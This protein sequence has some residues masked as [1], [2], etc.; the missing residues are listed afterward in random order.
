[1]NEAC[2]NLLGEDIASPKGKDFAVKVL[3][4]MRDKLV[5]FQEETGNIFN[6]KRLRPRGLLTVWPNWIRPCTWISSALMK[7]NM[8]KAMNLSIPIRRICR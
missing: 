6:L 4:F 7:T 3:K 5:E 1:M 8:P 2:L